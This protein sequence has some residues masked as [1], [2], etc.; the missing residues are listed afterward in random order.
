MQTFDGKYWHY[1]RP[2]QQVLAKSTVREFEVQS[3]LY[4]HPNWYPS[5][6]CGVA[7]R[8]GNDIVYVNRCPGDASGIVVNFNSPTNMQPI[9]TR[10]GGSYTVCLCSP[11]VVPDE[12]RSPSALERLL[13]SRT[14]EFTTTFTSQFL[15]LTMAT[16][17]VFAATTTA[18][19]TMMFPDM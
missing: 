19:L 1:Y 14:A 17:L 7:A 2:G 12:F 10:S 18:I 8:E 5:V 15:A 4:K 11:D 9:V 6:H 3:R 16:L 13:Q